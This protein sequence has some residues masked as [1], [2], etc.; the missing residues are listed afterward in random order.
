[1]TRTDLAALWE[2]LK[3]EWEG[4]SPSGRGLTPEWATALSLE[5]WC[6][7]CRKAV[8]ELDVKP[9]VNHNSPSRYAGTRNVAPCGRSLEQKWAELEFHTTRGRP[10]QLHGLLGGAKDGVGGAS[11]EGVWDSLWWEWESERLES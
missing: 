2:E 6:F 7:L 3:R 8:L 5:G 9:V 11:R 10:G 4:S 1:M